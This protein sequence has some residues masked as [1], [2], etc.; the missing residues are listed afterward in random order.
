MIELTGSDGSVKVHEVHAGDCT[1][2]LDS[3]LM[4]W[5]PP[6]GIGVPRLGLITEPNRG[7]AHHG[8]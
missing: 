4:G 8:D 1:L 2:T 6:D 5:T 3:V 7:A